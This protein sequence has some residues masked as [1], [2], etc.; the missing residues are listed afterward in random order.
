[1]NLHRTLP[2]TMLA[3]VSLTAFA[4]AKA[5]IEP[6]TDRSSKAE[7]FATGLIYPAGSS[8]G[9]TATCTSPRPVPA[10]SW[11]PTAPAPATPHRSRPTAAA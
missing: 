11:S 2:A 5:A 7:V 3:L 6:A 4:P 9:P 8:S 10:G 1:M